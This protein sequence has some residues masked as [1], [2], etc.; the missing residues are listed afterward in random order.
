MLTIPS[1]PDKKA[2]GIVDYG[3][4]DIY[5][6]TDAPIVNIELSAK[7]VKVGT[8]TGQNQQSTRTGEL[9]LPHIP[10]GFPIKGN[11][12]SGFRHNLIG[13]GPLCD[14]DCTVIFTREA[15]IVRYQQGTAVLTGWCEASG[16]RLWRID[17]QPGESNLTSMPK[18]ANMATLAAY[19]AYDPPRIADLIRYFHSAAGYP[20]QSTRLKAISA[21]N[22]SSWPGLTLV[23]ATKY[24]PC[25]DGTIMGHLVKKLQGV[26]STKQSNLTSM[27]KNANMATLAAYSAYDPPRIAD[28]IRYFHS[29]AGYPVQSTRLK[30]ISAGNYS[31]WPGLTLVNAT[32]YCPCD[33]GTIMGHLVKK[34]QGVRSTKHKPQQ[35]VHLKS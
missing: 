19:S 7:K 25:D 24:C 15:V 23:N 11:L 4:T 32:K 21:G 5:F 27:P 14:A 22:Y 35:Q 31:S 1:S 26:R 16:S 3:A 9:D 10:L 33:D 2:T 6:Y 34:L 18:N 28:L 29:A 8:L 17:L 13:V 20:V 30:A 12:M